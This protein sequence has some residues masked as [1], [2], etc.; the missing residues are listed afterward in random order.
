M[1]KNTTAKHTPTRKGLPG[2]MTR[3]RKYYK[4]KRTTLSLPTAIHTNTTFMANRDDEF[5]G[6]KTVRKHA[7]NKARAAGVNPNGKRFFHGLVP[8]GKPYDP[9]GWVDESN[10]KDEIKA[11]CKTNKF[12][13]EGLVTN[14]V[15]G[16]ERPDELS[17][18]DTMGLGKG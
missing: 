2:V 9:S 5:D 18:P 16:Y 6:D 13:C 17:Q 12:H 10:A 14:K 3:E 4:P 7:M 1:A 15:P 8:E 11:K